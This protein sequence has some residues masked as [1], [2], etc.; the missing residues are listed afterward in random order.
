MRQRPRLQIPSD[1]ERRRRQRVKGQRTGLPD[2]HLDLKIA[3]AGNEPDVTEL[4]ERAQRSRHLS[5]EAVIDTRVVELKHDPPRIG[6]VEFPADGAFAVCCDDKRNEPREITGSNHRRL[7]GLKNEVAQT[8]AK[9]DDVL[10]LFD[11]SVEGESYSGAAV[12]ADED[13]A[14]AAAIC[15]GFDPGA[16]MAIRQMC[17]VGHHEQIAKPGRKQDSVFIV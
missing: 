12:S 14:F 13:R 3:L 15:R 16:P 1:G 9:V 10:S 6:A 5:G 8:D 2:P 11:R 4:Q 17:R 7:A